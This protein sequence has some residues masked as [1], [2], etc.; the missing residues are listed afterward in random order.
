MR[1][2]ERWKQRAKGLLVNGKISWLDPYHIDKQS[3][4]NSLL[5]AKKYVKGLLL[6]LGC[7]SEP[8]RCLFS[9][10][11]G[12][13]IG[14]DLPTDTIIKSIDVYGD[15]LHL[16]FNTNSFDTIL[17]TQV[18][19][20]VPVPETMFN[21]MYHTLKK[22]GYLILTAP[23]VWGLHGEP[24]DYYRY[25][26]YGLKFLAEKSGFD[27]VYIKPR[28]GFFSMIGQRLSSYIFGLSAKKNL[29]W[30]SLIVGICTIIQL[31]FSFLDKVHTHYGDTLGY[32]MVAVKRR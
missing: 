6:D 29:V 9:A 4:V 8:Y 21:E 19:E 24:N 18:I 20:H 10:I 13:H 32:A 2:E 28:G 26:K 14:V 22:G 30:L 7:G 11:V 3:I 16:P 25:T 23:Q 12:E 15:G 31:V 1:I 17:C 27:I 5:D